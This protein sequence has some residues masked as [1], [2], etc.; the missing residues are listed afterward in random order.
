[1]STEP[2]RKR[3]IVNTEHLNDSGEFVTKKTR[4]NKKEQQ[5]QNV[6]NN[7][8]NNINK[9]LN[10]KPVSSKTIKSHTPKISLSLLNSIRKNYQKKQNL[11]NNIQETVLATSSEPEKKQSNKE[12]LSSL[13]FLK[14]VVQTTN[15]PIA[16]P[17]SPK[18]SPKTFPK[19]IPMN[20]HRIMTPQ[21][22]C[23]KHGVLPTYKT[24]KQL[25]QCS[26]QHSH[27]QPAMSYQ[28]PAMSYQQQPQPSMSYQQPAMSQQ[29]Q[30]AMSYQQQPL[31]AMSYQQPAMSQQQPEPTIPTKI[32]KT[33][34]RHNT[35]TICRTF[36]VGR[37]STKPV[38][39]VLLSNQDKR[40]RIL[41]QKQELNVIPLNKIRNELF[42]AGL[43]KI[44]SDAPENILRKMYE[45]MI[46]IGGPV[47]NFNPDIIAFN[48]LHRP[49]LYAN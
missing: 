7:G 33:A 45:N 16:T 4:K 46:L 22:G 32:F 27:Q 29:Q 38:V 48:L 30:P 3:I 39:S 14:Q 37:S 43:I 10:S 12:F 24:I 31:P 5:N 42:K 20:Q 6:S 36:K 21:Y 49:E 35:K 28:Q 41:Q 40:N 1:M 17:P 26:I 23:L 9:P 25:S 2:E 13:D 47:K 34:K 8:P 19:T 18:T 44:G 11:V 15:E